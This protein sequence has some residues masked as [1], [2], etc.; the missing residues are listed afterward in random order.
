[1]TFVLLYIIRVIKLRMIWAEHVTRV[2]YKDKGNGE[3]HPV[4]GHEGPE[5]L[6]GVRG[7]SHAPAAASP[8]KR[9]GTHCRGGWVGHRVGLDG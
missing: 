5:A 6:D 7:Q 3:Y 2:E 8:G 9:P 4:I 1:M